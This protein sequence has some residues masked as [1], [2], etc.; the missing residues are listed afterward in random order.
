MTLTINNYSILFKEYHVTY[1]IFWSY[2]W[3]SNIL[4]LVFF[5][6]NESAKE[7]LKNCVCVYVYVCVCAH[8]HMFSRDWLCDGCMGCSP[9]GSSVH[10]IFQARILEWVAVSSSKESSPPRN[11]TCIS[12][13]GRRTL[14]GWEALKDSKSPQSFFGEREWEK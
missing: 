9:A 8:A 12:Y 11:Q 14:Y 13:T 10:R 3:D 2:E 6:W 5:M 4:D 7:C 1:E